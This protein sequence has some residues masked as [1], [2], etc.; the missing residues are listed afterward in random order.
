MRTRR[1]PILKAGIKKDDVPALY[2]KLA[3]KYDT[4]AGL[5]EAK[6]RRRCLELADI[7]NGENVLEVAVGTGILF[8]EIL[9]ANPEGKNEGIDLTEEML[10]LARRRVEQLGV[11]SYRL[12]VG[13]ACALEYPDSE[14][15]VLINNYMFDLLPED[16]FPAI[17]AEFKRVLRPGGRLILVSMTK[18]EHWYSGVWEMLYR[19]NPA[20]M[21]GCRGVLLL[22]H[23]QAAGFR[24]TRREYVSQLT[25]ASEVVY[26]VR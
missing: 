20:L 7:R 18:A 14:F 16:D 9:R 6:A 13:D 1:S 3:P 19:I 10:A 11:G 15:D 26:G 25:F 8:A 22:P 5:T 4:W 17:L 2:R 12:A 23:L 21:G 24:D